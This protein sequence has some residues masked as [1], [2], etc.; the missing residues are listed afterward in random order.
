MSP[1]S[2]PR[3]GGGGRAPRHRPGHRRQPGDRPGVQRR[4]GGLA[5][6]LSRSHRHVR[7]GPDAGRPAGAAAHIGR[8][9]RRAAGRGGT[10]AGGGR[11][12]PQPAGGAEAGGRPRAG[13]DPAGAGPRRP[14]RPRRRARRPLG[15]RGDRGAFRAGSRPP[16]SAP[17]RDRAGAGRAVPGPRAGAGGARPHPR[18]GARPRP[19]AAGARRGVRLAG[20]PAGAGRHPRAPR[21][22]PPGGGAAASDA[23]GADGAQRPHPAQ[24]RA[25]LFRRRHGQAGGDAALRAPQHPLRPSPDHGQPGALHNRG[26]GRSRRS[27]SARA[28]DRALAHGTGGVRGAAR[29]DGRGRGRRPDPGGGGGAGRAW[30]LRRRLAEWAR[31]SQARSGRRWSTP[32]DDLRSGWRRAIPWSRPR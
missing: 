26:T 5:P 7:R 23:A 32:L 14:P 31:R 19:A 15:G 18:R 1:L 9:H 3:R 22:Q 27:A 20:I 10:P 13:A 11:A 6:R 17:G 16:Q 12:A 8:R 24:R 4:A 28:A 21:R 25:G 29:A 2:P 30:T